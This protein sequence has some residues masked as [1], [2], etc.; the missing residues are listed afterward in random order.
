MSHRPERWLSLAIGG[1]T[2]RAETTMTSTAAGMVI[3]I[4]LQVPLPPTT[5]AMNCGALEIV[6]AA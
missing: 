4:E 2:I 6:R 1:P 3:A 5:M